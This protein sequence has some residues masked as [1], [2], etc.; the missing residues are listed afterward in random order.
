MSCPPFWLE[1]P[2]VL[3][4]HAD[5][6]FPFTPTDQRCTSSALNS[7]TRFGIYLGVLLAIVRWAP[8]WVLVGAAFAAFAALAWWVM[9]TQ[10]TVRDGSEAF[11]N[12][13]DAVDGRT[14]QD[15][16]GIRLRTEPTAEN[17]FMNVLLTE[18]TDDPQRPPAAT[19]PELNKYFETLFHND[20]GDVFQHTQSQRQWVT[21][22][23]TTIPNDQD[24]FQKWLFW[25]PDDTCKEGN[26]KM[27]K[28]VMGG[29]EYP[30]LNS[31]SS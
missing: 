19:R 18:Y 28:P 10:G 22:P 16:R 2:S 6:F 31:F 23:S 13:V 14:V 30:W 25:T 20:P 7:F 17:P 8:T 15:V 11:V 4:N 24:A 1:S 21:M 27:C 3:W 5:E 26:M 12:P 29:G 9:N